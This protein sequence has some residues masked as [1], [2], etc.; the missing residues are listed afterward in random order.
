MARATE[1]IRTP[2]WLYVVMAAGLLLVVVPFLWMLVS[3][4]KP[5]AEVRAVPPTWWPETVTTENYDELFTRLDSPTYF[6]NSAIVALAVTAGNI[7]FCSM[8]G[9]A[10]AKLEFPGKRA[11]FGLVLGTLMVP[12][13]VTFV[14]L[15]VL[16]T[17]LGLA[18]ADQTPKPV[19]V[20]RWPVRDPRRRGRT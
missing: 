3:S 20:P 10:L 9:Y 17:N 5:E 13:V 15:F 19:D 2:R 16:V 11:L 1:Q 12:G 14:P 8:L 4:F 18:C 7:V 6:L